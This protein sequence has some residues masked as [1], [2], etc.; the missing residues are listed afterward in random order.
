MKRLMILGL[1]LIVAITANA[2]S[3]KKLDEEARVVVDS[4]GMQYPYA[5]WRKLLKTKQY[6][7]HKIDK[8]S[9][10]S[11]YLLVKLDSA[12]FDERMSKVVKP[13][14]SENFPIGKHVYLFSCMDIDGNKINVDE[15]KGKIVVLNF[16]F[17]G[18]GPCRKE[19]PELN[20]MAQA[21]ANDP[22]VVFI[23]VALDQK[24]DIRDFIRTTPL[25]YHIVD[26]G[27]YYAHRYGV[28]LYPTN[29][30]IDK[31]GNV[32]FSDMSYAINTA[33]WIKRT[34]EEIKKGG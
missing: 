22:D 16:W 6:R 29:A 3:Q 26:D 31:A 19:I 14:E 28:H 20:T 24:M 34:I 8:N 1:L 13:K 30:V 27:L 12:Q 17:I 10:S 33:Y 9:D 11:A 23:A 7:L 15:L 21:Y 4:S 32:R 2:Q 18:C 5:I 25:A